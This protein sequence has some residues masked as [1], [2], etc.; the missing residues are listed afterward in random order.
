MCFHANFETYC[1]L[2]KFTHMARILHDCQLWRSWQISALIRIKYLKGCIFLAQSWRVKHWSIA[3]NWRR[4]QYYPVKAWWVI[5]A[6]GCRLFLTE[7]QSQI[8]E[9]GW[10]YDFQTG[11]VWRRRSSTK[12]KNKQRNVNLNLFFVSLSPNLR[13][14]KGK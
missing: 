4:K 8:M 6:L 10:S 13:K 2:R 11:L 5:G 1:F 14:L 9:V 3:E 12:L 7:E